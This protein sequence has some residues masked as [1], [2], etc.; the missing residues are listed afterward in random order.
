MPKFEML[1][2]LLNFYINFTNKSNLKT[3][4]TSILKHLILKKDQIRG[5][6]GFSSAIEVYTINLVS[7]TLIFFELR[8]LEKC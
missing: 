7:H 8:V 3:T 2:F 1:I 6:V 4:E 5:R